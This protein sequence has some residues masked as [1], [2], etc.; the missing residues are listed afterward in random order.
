MMMTQSPCTR[1]SPSRLGSTP[2]R[3][4]ERVSAITAATAVAFA[5]VEVEQH[6]G[7]RIGVTVNLKW[8]GAPMPPPPPG[9]PLAVEVG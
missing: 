9:L 5:P 8:P 3:V 2:G 1:R 7:Q 6:P 4:P